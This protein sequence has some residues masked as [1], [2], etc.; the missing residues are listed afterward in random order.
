MAT[1]FEGESW[2]LCRELR[3]VYSKPSSNLKPS[4]CTTCI[5]VVATN[6]YMHVIHIV[7]ILGS[8]MV[9]GIPT[10]G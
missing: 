8:M 3:Q 5:H 2:Y 10:L 4:I 7:V 1:F 9:L 6:V